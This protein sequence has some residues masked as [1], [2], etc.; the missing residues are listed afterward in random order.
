MK[1]LIF[2]GSDRYSAIVLTHLLEHRNTG[3]LENF[4]VITDRPK[5]VG[6]DKSIATNPVE[7]LAI[8]RNIKVSYYPSND[9]EMNNLVAELSKQASESNQVYGLC[10]S[11]DHLVPASIIDTFGGN[12][13][14]LHPSLLPQYRNVSPVQYALALGDLQT[15]ITLFRISTGIDNGEIVGQV[16]E[17]IEQGDDTPSL[18]SRL[19]EKGAGLFLDFLQNS[20]ININKDSNL[21]SGKQIFT[22]RLTRDSGYLEWDVFQSLLKNAKIDPSMITNHLISL[23]LQ[24]NPGGNMMSDL[25]RALS[26]WPGV[27]TNAKTKKGDLRITLDSLDPVK[28][29]IAGKPN[30]ISYDDFKKYYLI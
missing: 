13:Y 4:V 8:E 17:P 27:W 5:P 24:H 6:K 14:N 18:T 1:Q 23:R 9:N 19:F 16:A 10:A 11:F 15:G 26:P 7:K 20:E 28:I 21:V 30:P 3:K 25:L 22:R 2:F 12:L 29:K